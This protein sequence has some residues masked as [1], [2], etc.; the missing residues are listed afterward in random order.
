MAEVK[1]PHPR[2]EVQRRLA[3]LSPVDDNVVHGYLAG[4]GLPATAENKAAFEAE[5]DILT[6]GEAN[7]ANAFFAGLGDDVLARKFAYYCQTM[8]LLSKDN[9]YNA[10]INKYP[11][12]YACARGAKPSDFKN[13]RE[14]AFYVGYST[15]LD[16]Q[17]AGALELLIDIAYKA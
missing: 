4:C 10:K 17:Y 12:A 3:L 15:D 6:Y 13:N 11:I 1:H 16:A 14:P 5:E 7:V 2:E 8:E 9:P